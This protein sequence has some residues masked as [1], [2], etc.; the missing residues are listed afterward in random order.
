MIKKT[1]ERELGRSKRKDKILLGLL[2][3]IY[4][5]NLVGGLLSNGHLSSGHLSKL[6]TLLLFL[7]DC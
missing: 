6:G 3:F 5:V 7:L 2:H 4:E 1:V